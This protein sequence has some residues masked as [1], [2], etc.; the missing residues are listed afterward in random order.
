MKFDVKNKATYD[1]AITQDIGSKIIF[2]FV[3]H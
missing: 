2:V 3:C 1:F